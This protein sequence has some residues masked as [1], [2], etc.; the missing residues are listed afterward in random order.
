[1]DRYALLKTTILANMEKIEDLS[2]RKGIENR[3]IYRNEFPVINREN[4][5]LRHRLHIL[6]KD[7][8]QFEKELKRYRESEVI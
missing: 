7:S 2:K 1:M 5:E 4:V 3:I 6:R 8:L